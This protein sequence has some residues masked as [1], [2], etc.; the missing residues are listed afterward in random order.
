MQVD[1]GL[2][3]PHRVSSHNHSTV[4]FCLTC[5]NLTHLL[6][7]T[8]YFLGTA[9][10]LGTARRGLPGI[11]P[12]DKLEALESYIAFLEISYPMSVYSACDKTLP[13]LAQRL[14]VPVG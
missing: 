2:R 9:Y 10:L 14:Y 12:S 4:P 13:Q 7:V 8:A 5:A 1:R 11:T 6:N 3:R